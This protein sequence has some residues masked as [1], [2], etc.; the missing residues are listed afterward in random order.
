MLTLVRA[1]V[2]KAA[3]RSTVACVHS[4][5]SS[6]DSLVTCSASVCSHVPLFVAH[7]VLPWK[8]RRYLVLHNRLKNSYLA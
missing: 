3:G 1:D 8:V 4:A 5:I 6:D 7:G 2:V